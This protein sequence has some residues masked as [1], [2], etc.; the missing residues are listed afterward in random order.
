MIGLSSS[1][2]EHWIA[3]NILSPVETEYFDSY[4][5]AWEDYPHLVLPTTRLV[6][7]NCMQLQ[8]DV[9]YLCG[10][11]CLLFIYQRS[12]GVSYE[13]FLKD[14]N[15]DPSYNDW[16]VSTFV[17][18]LLTFRPYHNYVKHGDRLIGCKRKCES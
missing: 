3:W 6:E 12:R 14:F 18:K 8:S 13:D 15:S 7:E 9:S 11:Y 5:Q 10:Q 17:K 4:G 2:G 16:V 1:S